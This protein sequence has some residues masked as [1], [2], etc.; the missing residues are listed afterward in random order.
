[1]FFGLGPTHLYVESISFIVKITVSYFVFIT[2]EFNFSLGKGPLKNTRYKRGALGM[3]AME[4]TAF[5][6]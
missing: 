5:H 1:M 3:T 4:T 6:K 2:K